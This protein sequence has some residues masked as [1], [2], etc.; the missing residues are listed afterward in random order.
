MRDIIDVIIC[1]VLV[2]YEDPLADASCDL[3]FKP[4][5]FHLKTYIQGSLT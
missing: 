5:Q 1:F 4:S 3:S 2:R